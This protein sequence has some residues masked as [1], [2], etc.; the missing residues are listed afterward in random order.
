MNDIE[1]V[2]SHTGRYLAILADESHGCDRHCACG[3]VLLD[4]FQ[5]ECEHCHG[6]IQEKAA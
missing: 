5:L 4:P 6:S 1:E 3:S 2:L